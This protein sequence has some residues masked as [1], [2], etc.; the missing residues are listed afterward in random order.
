MQQELS[1]V[2]QVSGPEKKGI[3]FTGTEYTK[4]GVSIPGKKCES[5][6]GQSLCQMT[7]GKTSGVAGWHRR[8]KWD[9][10]APHVIISEA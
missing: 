7:L 2:Y 3:T 6:I 9:I 4:N 5:C 10:C 1:E 8:G